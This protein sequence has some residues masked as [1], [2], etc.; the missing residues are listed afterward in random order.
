L[1]DLADAC[2]TVGV[3]NE[4]SAPFEDIAFVLNHIVG[5]GELAEIPLFA[6]AD[7]ETITGVIEEA[8]RFMS[9]VVAPLNRIGDTQGSRL[10]A[11]GSVTTPDG[12]KEAYARYVEAGWGAVAFPVEFGGGGF[13]WVV[14]VV[15]QE[16][17]TSACMSFSLAP[18]LTQGAIDALIHHGSEQQQHLYLEKMITGEWTGTM[19]LTE[20]QAGSDVGALSSKAVPA[21]DGSYR[22][23]GTKIF[24]T[25]GEQDL[26]D[27]IV[28]LVLARTPDAPPGTRGISCF[29]VPKYIPK[30]D[31]SPGEKNDV[32]CV[33]LEHKLGIHGSPTCV[34]SY[35][36]Q[37]E[38]AVGYLIGD[39]NQGMRY[40]FTMMNNA[41]LSVGLEG[42]ALGERSYQQAVSYAAERTQGRAIGAP[43]GAVSPIIDHPDVRRMVLTMRSHIEALRALVYTNA[44]AIDRA[45]HHPDEA[46]RNENRELADILT[47]ITKGWGT[48]TG[49]ALTSLGVQIHGGMGF[50]EETGAAQHLRDIRIAPIYEGT[51]GI[52]AADLVGRKLAMREGRAVGALI[53]R[54]A[55]LAAEL[56]STDDEFSTVGESLAD[57]V[58]T[59][60]GATEW[61]AQHGSVNPNDALAGSS[62][63]LEM[64]GL[65]LGGWFL[66]RSA[67]AARGELLEGSQDPN[68]RSFLEA[69]VVTARFYVGQILP[70]VHGL[71]GA[72]RGGSDILFELSA[73]ALGA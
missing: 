50:I 19:N 29:I 21:E 73:D 39:E 45:A 51:N 13:P 71:A 36:D 68:R 11:D 27:Q 9:E 10:G 35:G 20:P 46:V 12:F 56:A 7:P 61:L 26:T 62:P 69:K 37:G 64:F 17:L 70:K 4:Y 72:V 67:V 23:T 41:R 22:V 42:L 14:G 47:P 55:E 6:H 18:L 59:L 44:A 43:R 38:G 49:V 40:M 53:D 16:L 32:T 31:G 63:Y 58:G 34:L 2:S 30:A 3:V 24:I 48:D 54:M 1:S 57:A 60:R 66:A 15:L 33:S 25:Y 5:I 65:T 8:G 28:H 52:Q